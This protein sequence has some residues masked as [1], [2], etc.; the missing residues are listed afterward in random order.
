MRERII[1]L[2]HHCFWNRKNRRKSQNP[3]QKTHQNQTIPDLHATLHQSRHHPATDI[4]YPDYHGSSSHRGSHPSGRDNLC[5]R[6]PLLY[7]TY[8]IARKCIEFGIPWKNIAK[9][10]AASAVMAAVLLVIPHP[11][12]ILYTV[13]VTLLGGAIYILILLPTDREIRSLTKSIIQETMRIMKL[14]K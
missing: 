11:T 13:A 2:R 14:S 10:V 1:G 5:N 12:R 6:H 9:Y 7:A 4:F 8:A 3:L